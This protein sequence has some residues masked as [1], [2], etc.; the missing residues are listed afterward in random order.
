MSNDQLK[1]VLSVDNIRLKAKHGWYREER[2]IGGY[3]CINIRMESRAAKSESFDQLDSTVN[4][5][6][7]YNSVISV[8][9]N[10]HK[11][12]EHCCKAIFDQLKSLAANN[13]W[14]VELIK[15]NP[16]IKYIGATRF[17]IEG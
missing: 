7:I 4:Y 5:E 15:E 17:K 16:P 14:T 1:T 2:L 13:I 10:E 11:L 8:M 3:Y 12:I 6:L 9:K